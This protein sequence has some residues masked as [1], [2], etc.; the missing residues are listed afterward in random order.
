MIK[1]NYYQ[2][3]TFNLSESSKVR[4]SYFYRVIGLII[5]TFLFYVISILLR[6]ETSPELSNFLNI[7]IKG[8][9]VWLSYLFIIA[10]V[11]M[12]LYLH[13]LIHASVFFL[14]S[15]VKPKIGIKGFLIFASSEEVLYKKSTMI[16]NALSP[17]IVIS[18]LGL[19]FISIIN[20]QFLFWIFLPVVVNA[21][22]SSGDFMASNW[23]RSLPN[24]AL[25]EDKGY[26]LIAYQS[27]NK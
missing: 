25:I 16:L 4:I 2:I 11:F 12:V 9:D 14:S 18:I 23:L 21:A 17:F 7:Q 10:D 15:R 3:S 5:F 1:N 19:I 20:T 22:A 13:E 6:N 24:D 27:N 26:L 8:L